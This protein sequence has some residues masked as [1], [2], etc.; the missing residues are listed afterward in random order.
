MPKTKINPQ[1]LKLELIEQLCQANTKKD[2]EKICFSGLV[3]TVCTE[4]NNKK[5]DCVA[6]LCDAIE[7]D[8]YID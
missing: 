8:L 5:K 7:V 6:E 3:K 2:I 1:K 4:S